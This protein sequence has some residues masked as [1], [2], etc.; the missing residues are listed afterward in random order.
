MLA[1]QPVII[2]REN[3]ERTHGY[4]A[5]RSNIAAAKALAEAVRTTLGP[6]GMDKMLI[7]GTGDITITN[8][9]ITILDE[10]SVQHPGAKMVIEVSRTQD[11][12][13]GDGTTTAV[14]LVGSMMEQAEILLNKKIHPTVICRD[15]PGSRTGSSGR[16]G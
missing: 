8:D 12:E 14:V 5:Q 16:N 6:R 2:L 3:V 7:D 13:V 15:G 4:E 1:Q 11:E 9:G 10:I